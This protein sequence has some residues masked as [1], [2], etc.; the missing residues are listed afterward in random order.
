M[1]SSDLS[2][3]ATISGGDDGGYFGSAIAVS[4][5]LGVGRNDVETVYIG[6]YDAKKGG[7]G[8]VGAV[9]ALAGDRLESVVWQATGQKRR[10]RF[11]WS[12]ACGD[13]VT[14]DGVADLLVSAP[15]YGV[16]LPDGGAQIIGR[17]ALLSGADGSEV[18]QFLGPRP[19]DMWPRGS[20]GFGHVVA[21]VGDLD[22][23]GL[24]DWAVSE[25]RQL[26]EDP[27]YPGSVTLLSARSLAV[28][29]VMID[30]ES[31]K[32]FG[33]RVADAG[34][35]DGDGISDIEISTDRRADGRRPCL[36]FSGHTRTVIEE[37]VTDGASV[38]PFAEFSRID[39][40]R[41][42]ID[43]IVL[44]LRDGN[45]AR[46]FAAFDRQSGRLLETWPELDVVVSKRW[47][48]Q[49]ATGR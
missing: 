20:I 15:H 26:K 44:R 8:R 36:I 43:D 25:S 6:A 19:S 2:L 32:G 11:G 34:D 40:N 7:D 31:A 41:D 4:S 49:V 14:G 27:P 23:D 18:E 38:S 16:E 33:A 29:D 28:I 42:G 10:E 17:V 22:G 5:R 39:A 48:E 13:D 45:R 3:L 9:T 37:I 12:I 35:I 47:Q 24:R 46:H 30:P 1:S 21:S